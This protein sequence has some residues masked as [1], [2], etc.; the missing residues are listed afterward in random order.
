M[1]KSSLVNLGVLLFFAVILLALFLGGSLIN[2]VSEKKYVAT[3]TEKDT[4]LKDDDEKYLIYTKLENGETRVF[5]IT[6]NLYEFKFNSSDIYAEIQEG[7]T[8]EFFTT[9]F[10]VPVLSMYENINEFTLLE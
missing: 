6:D 2:S 5:E 4:K 3:V 10:R 1:K 7:E 9:G 8:Y